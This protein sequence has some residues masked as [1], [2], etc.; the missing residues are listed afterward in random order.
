MW[1]DGPERPGRTALASRSHVVLAR[2]VLC[3][4]W[5]TYRPALAPLF[6][7]AQSN[8]NSDKIRGVEMHRDSGREA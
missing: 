2:Y 8:G 4:N 3:V 6:Y 5:D 7:R 1:G